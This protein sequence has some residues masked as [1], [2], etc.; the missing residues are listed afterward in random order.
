VGEVKVEL[1]G[2]VG[3]TAEGRGPEKG[4]HRAEREKAG[5]A[6]AGLQNKTVEMACAGEQGEP[7]AD[8]GDEALGIGAEAGAGGGGGWRRE[9]WA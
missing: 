4:G 1:A 2:F 6:M 7:V 3:N 9:G 5:A 8:E